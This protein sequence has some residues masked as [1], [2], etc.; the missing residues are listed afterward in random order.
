MCK[1]SQEKR[2]RS[3]G[4]T[5]KQ[6]GDDLQAKDQISRQYRNCVPELYRSGTVFRY[7]NSSRFIIPVLSSG[8]VM[9]RTS[10]CRIIITFDP[11]V[12]LS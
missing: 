5:P 9:L 4:G 10:F 11:T 8:T 7:F 6:V 2:G 1:R 12:R 3:V